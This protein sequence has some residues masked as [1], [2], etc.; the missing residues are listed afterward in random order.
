MKHFLLGFLVMSVSCQTSKQATRQLPTI[1]ISEQEKG[2]ALILANDCTTCHKPS[3]KSIGPAFVQVALK[4]DSSEVNIACL[5]NKIKNGGEG[6]WGKV[7]MTP[8]FD[9]PESDLRE[10][11]KYIFSLKKIVHE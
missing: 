1:E 5:V 9:L 7:P 8:H 4:Y 10:V 2:G 3:A 11:V 6:L